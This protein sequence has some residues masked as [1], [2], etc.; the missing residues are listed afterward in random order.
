MRQQQL[1]SAGHCCRRLLP[2]TH[3]HLY[4]P[5]AQE[6]VPQ[7]IYYRPHHFPFLDPAHLPYILSPHV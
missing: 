7:L 6:G 4:L 5:D 1:V 2:L 3:V